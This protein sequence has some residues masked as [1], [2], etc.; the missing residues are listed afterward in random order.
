MLGDTAALW[1]NFGAAL[2]LG[3]VF[4]PLFS[5]PEHGDWYLWNYHFLFREGIWIL[6]AVP[7][8]S[9]LIASFSKFLFPLL[10]LRLGTLVLRIILLLFTIVGSVGCYLLYTR[11]LL[12]L[13]FDAIVPGITSVLSFFSFNHCFVQFRTRPDS[14][15]SLHRMEWLS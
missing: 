2:S 13:F 6:Y 4:L 10:S 1:L 3:A 7:V 14:T 8:L 9:A 12:Y 5:T 15:F 11:I